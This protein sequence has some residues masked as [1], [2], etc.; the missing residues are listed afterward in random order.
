MSTSRNVRSW[1]EKGKG[2]GKFGI[3][4][5]CQTS[6]IKFQ[7]QEYGLKGW[8]S[9]QSY[10]GYDATNKAIKNETQFESRETVGQYGGLSK[11]ADVNPLTSC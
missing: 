6:L 3:F 4:F 10:L 9:L 11:D 2:I 7:A 5:V 8:S 1:R